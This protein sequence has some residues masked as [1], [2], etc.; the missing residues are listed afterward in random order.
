MIVRDSHQSGFHGA[1]Q[2][3][4]ED[5]VLALSSVGVVTE[6]VGF[7]APEGVGSVGRE[8]RILFREDR[9]TVEHHGVEHITTPRWTRGRDQRETVDITWALLRHRSGLSLLRF[10]GHLPA[11][12][13][14][15]AQLAA[16]KT[17]LDGLAGVVEPLQAHYSPD[18]TTGSLDFNRNLKAAS[19]RR[20][21][22]EACG[23]T[24]LRLV[25]PPK[26]TRRLR[27]IDGFL[28]TGDLASAGMLDRRKGF[29]HR[30]ASLVS[31]GCPSA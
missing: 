22:R 26:A 30:G 31:C 18:V 23:E 2:T 29:D 7:K 5:A 9:W 10:G 12:L 13:F 4:W 16:N 15:A 3:Q 11:H 24:G 20:I 17:A 28:T 8:T 25:V 1:T 21:I 27:T 14:N 19:Q 6:S